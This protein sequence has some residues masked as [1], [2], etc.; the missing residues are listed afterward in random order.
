MKYVV[1]LVV[2]V[3]LALGTDTNT[4]QKKPVKKVYPRGT[5]S[6]H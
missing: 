6:T 5:I 4:S 2:F 3:T 1:I